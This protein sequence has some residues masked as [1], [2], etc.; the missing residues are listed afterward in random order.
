MAAVFFF[1][2]KPRSGISG[3]RTRRLISGIPL[4]QSLLHLNVIGGKETELAVALA[5]PPTLVNHFDVGDDV[6]G[7]E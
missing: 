4:L 1:L 7:I 2:S 3:R 5:E 6:V